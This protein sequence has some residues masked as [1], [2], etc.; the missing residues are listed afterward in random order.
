MSMTGWKLSIP[1]SKD[2]GNIA[3][4]IPLNVHRSYNYHDVRIQ[5]NLFHSLNSS[6]QKYNQN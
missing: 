5:I 2:E 6:A 1:V 3:D 4:K